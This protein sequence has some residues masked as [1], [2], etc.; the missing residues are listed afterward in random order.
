[1]FN[2]QDKF[3]IKAT[4]YEEEKDAKVFLVLQGNRF[5]CLE[6]LKI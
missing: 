2:V 3:N 4:W 6:E 5:L 1:M